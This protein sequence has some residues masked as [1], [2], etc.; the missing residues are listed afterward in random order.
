[1]RKHPNPCPPGLLR[2]APP[3]PPPPKYY[4]P[5]EGLLTAK[6]LLEFRRNVVE[7]VRLMRAYAAES[8]VEEVQRVLNATADRLEGIIGGAP[9]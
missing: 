5:G 4:A 7:E 9:V 6:L 2:P 1:M 3:P 8:H